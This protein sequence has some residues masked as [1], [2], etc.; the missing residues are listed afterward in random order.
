[1]AFSLVNHGNY[2]PLLGPLGIDVAINPR[3]T[4]VS[5]VLRH[6][7]RGRI[8]AVQSIVDGAAEVFEAEALSTSPLVGIPIKEARLPQGVVI[9]AV[10]RGKQVLTPRGE[11]VVQAGDRVI[12]AARAV[13]V[14]RVE[15]LFAVRLDYF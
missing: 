1:L 11:T 3:E 10:V 13:M 9:A 14:K 7:R 4:T 12:V 8:R 5:S 2:A 6:V 15:K